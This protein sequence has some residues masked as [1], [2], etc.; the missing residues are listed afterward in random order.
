MW[1]AGTN[2]N[3]DR[4]GYATS[5]D[6]IIWTKDTLHNPVL[7]IGASGSWD[8]A[9]VDPGPVQYD[10]TT[11]EM[12]Y[13]GFDGTGLSGRVCGFNLMVLPGKNRAIWYYR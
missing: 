8:D 13:S 7:N 5:P 12:L 4:V 6:G 9:G 1:Y 3:T 10:G 2:G 11:F